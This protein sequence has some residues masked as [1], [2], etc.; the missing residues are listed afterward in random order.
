MKSNVKISID[1]NK[2]QKAMKDIAMKAATTEGLEIEC[3]NCHKHI[4]VKSGEC[5]PFCGIEI[6]FVDGH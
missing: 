3:P 6:N 5:C 2:L 4:K 1:T